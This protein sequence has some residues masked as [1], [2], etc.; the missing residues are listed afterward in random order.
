MKKHSMVVNRK[1]AGFTLIELLVVVAIIALLAALLFPVFARA[2]ANAQRTS[3]AN[4][5]KQ[6]GLG[7]LQYAQDYDETMVANRYN[8]NTCGG[9]TGSAAD[10]GCGNY[11]WMDAI[12]PY[13]KSEQI[14][15]CPSVSSKVA[16]YNYKACQNLA[17][18]PSTDQYGTYALN[19]AY[20]NPASNDA[21]QPPVSYNWGANGMVDRKVAELDTPSTTFLA[22]DSSAGNSTDAIYAIHFDPIS[23]IASGYFADF[24]SIT[25]GTQKGFGPSVNSFYHVIHLETTNILFADGHVKA[26]TTKQVMIASPTNS[27]LFPMF[28][29]QAD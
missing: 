18:C 23:S 24:Y 13:V 2:R 3:C 17:S 14:F 25:N 12:Y 27:K 6:I 15:K 16:V 21:R 5:L 10:T 11:K 9:Q 20:A 7:I 4:N 22:A 28:T 1:P 8:N 29:T 26:M 19:I